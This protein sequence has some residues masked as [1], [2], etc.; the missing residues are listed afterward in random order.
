MRLTAIGAAA[1]ALLICLSACGDDEPE[2]DS[3]KPEKSTSASAE[4]SDSGRLGGEEPDYESHAICESITADDVSEV[5][6]EPVKQDS[7][8]PETCTFKAKGKKPAVQGVLAEGSVDA[9]G[10][11]KQLKATLK[12]EGGEKIDGLGDLAF[13]GSAPM[14]NG[15]TTAAGAV[16]VGDSVIRVSLTFTQVDGDDEAKDRVKGILELVADNL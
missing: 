12:Q 15:G 10:G 4:S 3:K 16:V 1:S 2:R 13:V 8:R 14:P 11:R 6:G 9:V 5:L 7:L